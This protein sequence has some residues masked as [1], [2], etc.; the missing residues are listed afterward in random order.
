M[1]TDPE[2]FRN[3]FYISLEEVVLLIFFSI[4]LLEGNALG[5]CK[6]GGSKRLLSR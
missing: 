5:F 1:K 2:F 4:A 3:P 6:K